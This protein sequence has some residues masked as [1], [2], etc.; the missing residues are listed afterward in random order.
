[1]V[2]SDKLVRMRKKNGWSQEELAEKVGVSRQ[3][4]SKWE[5]AQ[6]VPEIEKILLLSEMFGVTTDYLL[7]E[8]IEN[9]EPAD[10][11]ILK[12]A[13]RVTAADAEEY[14]GYRKKASVLI[15][16]GVFLCIMSP[17]P[18]II[19]YALRKFYNVMTNAAVFT[20]I[21]LILVFV[22]TAVG[23]FSYCNFKNSPFEYLSKD[24][25]TE[26][27]VDDMVRERDARFTPFGIATN[28]I[29]TCLCVVSCTPI[30]IAAFFGNGFAIYLSVV[31]TLALVG[32]AVMLYIIG[33]VRS[34]SMHRLLKI[35]EFS[36][37]GKRKGETSADT[38]AI[39]WITVTAVYLGWSFISNR[40]GLTWIIWPVAGA[41]FP[42][43]YI[44]VRKIY[45][46]RALNDEKK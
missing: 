44:T 33:T 39:Y 38:S 12:K 2:L 22:A 19:L 43:V 28:I 29:A 34:R 21:I 1:M 13:K 31:A 42:V 46:K 6:S 30:L 9:E 27:G 41:F 23:L 37:E 36:K 7:K 35:G 15:A 4:V 24:F 14:I 8:Y 17:T 20:G 10:S 45:D 26:H 16:S 11:V 32:I 25:E 5:S 40:W 3:A 18:L